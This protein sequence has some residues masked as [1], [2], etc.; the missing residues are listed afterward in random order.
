MPQSVSHISTVE[1][2]SLIRRQNNHKM[3][4]SI[5]FNSSRLPEMVSSRLF[6]LKVVSGE[7]RKRPCSFSVFNR[8]VLAIALSGYHFHNTERFHEIIVGSLVQGMVV[9][10]GTENHDRNLI[11]FFPYKA[12][13]FV[14]VFSR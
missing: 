14:A 1:I 3:F 8:L 5:L 11:P 13:Q 7:T 6:L 10:D 4:D 2:T 12:N 9:I